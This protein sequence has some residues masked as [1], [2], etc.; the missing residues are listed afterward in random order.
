MDHTQRGFA[1]VCFE[2][3]ESAKK[4]AAGDANSFIFE[5]K[6]NR[7]TVGKLI[8]NLYFK[9]IPETMTNE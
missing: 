4:A 1:Y 8:N 9:N 7:N 6:E 5:Q 2:D 3:Q